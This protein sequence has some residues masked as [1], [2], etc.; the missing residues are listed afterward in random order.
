MRLCGGEGLRDIIDSLPNPTSGVDEH[1]KTKTKLDAIF[2]AKKNT[3]VLVT[4]FQHMRQQEDESA[5]EYYAHLPHEATKCEFHNAELEIK[6]HVQDTRRDRRLPKKAVKDQLSVDKML[7]EVSHIDL[8]NAW[9]VIQ[10]VIK[11][12][13]QKI[14]LTKN[15]RYDSCRISCRYS[16]RINVVLSQWKVVEWNDCKRV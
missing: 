11:Y 14:H 2:L 12:I 6:R 9:K 16:L 13:L 1:Q 10:L 3:D 8:G 5:V 15:I 7:Q 4:R